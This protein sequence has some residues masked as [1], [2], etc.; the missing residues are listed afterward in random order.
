MEENTVARKSYQLRAL[1]RRGIIGIIVGNLVEDSFGARNY[2]M[3]S[4]YNA[5]N[6]FNMPVSPGN[7]N[8]FPDVPDGI[9]RG[10]PSNLKFK[11][12]NSYYLPI[13][14]EDQTER[15][16]FTLSDSAPS[17]VWQFGHDY[18]FS[19]PYQKD[20]NVTD[21]VR[22]DTTT[23]P[24][25]LGGWFSTDFLQSGLTSLMVNQKL[26]W[27]I[28]R[29][30]SD[31]SAGYMENTG[32]INLT[33]PAA[34]T[35][36]QTAP[37]NGIQ[38]MLLA[39]ST[40]SALKNVKGSGILG[41]IDRNFWVNLGNIQIPGTNMSMV[42]PNGIIS[43][44]WFETDRYNGYTSQ[45]MDLELKG[46]IMN[47]HEQFSQVDTG[48]FNALRANS[49]DPE[50]FAS[51]LRYYGAV[52]NIV[53]QMPSA[54]ILFDV[55]NSASGDW[56]YTLQI[57]ENDQISSAG[58]Y[59]PV[60]DRM[61]VHQTQLSNGLLRSSLGDDTAKIEHSLRAMPQGFLQRF[62]VPIG[63]L[64]GGS[65]FPF[66]VSFLIA[67]FVVLLVREKEERILVMMQ[68][69]GL[70]NKAYYLGHYL[71][72]LVLTVVSSIVFLV[73]GIAFKLEMFTE[74]SKAL[75]IVLLFVWWNLQIA[76]SFFFSTFFNN[77]RVALVITNLIVF[78]GVV[79][80]ATVT[81]IFDTTIPI[82]YLL[83]PP[84]AMYRAIAALNNA[85]VSTERPGYTFSDVVSG[86]VVFNCLIAMAIEWLVLLVLSFYLMNV[87]PGKYGVKRPWHFPITDLFRKEDE[88][89]EDPGA[90][91]EE[92]LKLEDQ[93]VKNE[94]SRII[95]GK[96]PRDSPLILRRVRKVYPGGKL[97]VKDISFAISKGD[98]F[99][100]LGPNG[101]GKTTLISM[102]SGL[103][104]VSGG[105]AK[106]SGFNVTTETKQVYRHIGIC[107]QHDIL[108]DDLTIAEHL[109]F[110]ARLKGIPAR[111]ERQ[112]VEKIIKDVDLYSK[113]NALSKNLSG[114]QKRRLSIAISFVGNPS[115]VFLDEPTTGLDPEVRRTVW[116]VINRNKVGRT[117][118]ITTHSME[119]AEVLCTK[120]GIMAHGT[121]RCFGTQLRLKQLYGSGFLLM[122][123][124]DE[125]KMPDVVSYISSLLP[126]D[127]TLVDSFS[128]TVSWEF[129]PEPGLI[130]RL[131]SEIS[132]NK[133]AYS[134]NDWG[135]SQTSLDEVFLRIIG[136]NDADAV[137]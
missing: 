132:Q 69:N 103:Y 27:A 73:S 34:I 17:C 26:T 105:V 87:L 116:N 16:P 35:Q 45:Q 78:W 50:N 3:C 130:P 111:E 11:A 61:F 31:G 96:Y 48:V 25:P 32:M 46:K 93:D 15:R 117:I 121:M 80:D 14:I 18:S 58:S 133:A 37:L 67:S 128:N 98:I 29:D 110:Y 28:V 100:L 79:I 136:E 53:A 71:H 22:L 107:P 76:I 119:E 125:A 55:A 30:A 2:L 4:N 134:I 10:Y 124:A 39:N 5:T 127:A 85:A 23:K 89:P 60:M 112:V 94:R 33:T 41:K 88:I 65:L 51:L 118:V 104:K 91:D 6:E 24:D 66:G 86:D 84:F 97:A 99:G 59:P 9:V 12:S 8:N 70:K 52:G 82:P 120:I 7:I 137:Q 13:Q 75:L 115:V 108:W 19:S 106:L 123:S 95:D 131:F 68:M 101:A 47:V 43:T 62:T 90:L 20:P 74:T 77:S 57:G 42:G 114:G 129:K 40:Q 1:A 126:P 56:R 122:A 81:F 36:M 64:I 135:I 54:A 38:G 49:S 21:A 92:E 72:F 113:R 102:L 63:S 83:W 44:P 109:Y